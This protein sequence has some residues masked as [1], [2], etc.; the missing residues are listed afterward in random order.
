MRGPRSQASSRS[1]SRDA[2]P[3][4][5]TSQENQ[6]ADSQPF[7]GTQGLP[8][9]RRARQAVDG[10]IRLAGGPLDHAGE[11]EG[12]WDYVAIEMMGSIVLLDD[13]HSEDGTVV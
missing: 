10:G 13:E 1:S 8:N 6:F 4:P 11:P 7:G 3:L 12:D 2:P 9:T 5:H